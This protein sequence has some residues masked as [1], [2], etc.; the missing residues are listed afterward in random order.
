MAV[1]FKICPR[2]QAQAPINAQTCVSCGHAFRTQFTQA[3]T[4]D[5]SAWLQGVDVEL[6]TRRPDV[7]FSNLDPN[8]MHL[9]FQAGMTPAS[10][11]A[12]PQL[13]LKPLPPGYSGY[14][15]GYGQNPYPP[16]APRMIQVPPGIHSVVPAVALNLCCVTGFGQIYNKQILKG[17][18][19][20]LCSLFLSVITYGVGGFVVAVA[21]IVDAYMIARKLESG[22]PVGE[23]E[24]F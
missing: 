9:A 16:M 15:P 19:I 11:V 18:V 1:Q 10:F 2:C 23:W 3:V 4:L 14:S 8:A 21:A 24:F 6:R 20:L 17:I 13:P 22:R 5:Y 12:Q 7:T